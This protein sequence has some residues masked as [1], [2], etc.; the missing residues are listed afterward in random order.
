VKPLKTHRLA[1]RSLFAGQTLA[2][3][4]VACVSLYGGPASAATLAVQV[5]DANG[6]P[7]ADAAVFLESKEA[8]AAA[9]PGREVAVEQVDRQFKPRMSI[10]TAG[11]AVVFPNLDKVRH[12]VYSFS[13]TKNFE[14]KLYAGTP[15][16]P[17]VFERSGIALLGCNIHDNMSAWVVVVDTPYFG[18]TDADGRVALERV[19]TGAYQLRAWHTSQPVGAPASEQAVA[20]ADSPSSAS[21]LT[22]L[23]LKDAKP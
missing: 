11:T 15:T 5:F 9:K 17:V 4:F 23:T 21:S 18:R 1:N 14:L 6:K 10:V 16:S 2:Y 13:P 12:H 7:L 8:R 19:P 3:A 22:R 20:V